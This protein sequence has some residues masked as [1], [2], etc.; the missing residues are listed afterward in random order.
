[1]S[2][3]INRRKYL[4]GIKAFGEYI[5]IYPP[6]YTCGKYIQKNPHPIQSIFL[7]RLRGLI[8][9]HPITASLYGT[10]TAPP[11]TIRW[12]GR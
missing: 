11:I 6:I 10:P 12:G 8:D 3:D 5:I 2:G 4:N 9:E 7:N 1:L